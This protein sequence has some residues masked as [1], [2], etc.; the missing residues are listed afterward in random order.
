VGWAKVGHSLLGGG[1][2]NRTTKRENNEN[3][4]GCQEN[5]M[6]ESRRQLW[7]CFPKFGSRKW[8]SKSKGFEYFSY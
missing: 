7:N 6:P 2:D 3:L 4:M 5:F 8:D 1:L